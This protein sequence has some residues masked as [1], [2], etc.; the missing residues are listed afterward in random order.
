MKRAKRL[1][2]TKVTIGEARQPELLVIDEMHL[3]TGSQ[4]FSSAMQKWQSDFRRPNAEAFIATQAIVRSNSGKRLRFLGV[5]KRADGSPLKPAP[6]KFIPAQ[7][8]RR[9]AG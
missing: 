1:R 6:K 7:V 8:L 2:P 3:L 9:L 5:T 4:A